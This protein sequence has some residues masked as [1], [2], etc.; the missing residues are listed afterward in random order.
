[1][2]VA[3]VEQAVLCIRL[4]ERTR[5]MTQGVAVLTYGPTGTNRS[6]TLYTGGSTGLGGRDVSKI[7]DSLAYQA[8]V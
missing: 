6:P 1:M 2:S 7:G 4:W 8:A 5:G 3:D